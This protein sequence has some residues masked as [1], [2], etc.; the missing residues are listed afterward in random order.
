DLG[1]LDF[2]S[3]DARA[4]Y[5]AEEL[6]LN[7]RTAPDLYLD[8]IPL[9]GTPDDPVP[10]ALPA[11]EHAV[12]MRRFDSACLL[13]RMAAERRLTAAQIDALAASVAQ[14]HAAAARAGPND[15]YGT[16]E[17]I[18]RPVRQNFEQIAPRLSDTA[19][20]AELAQC[21]A[22]AGHMQEQLA[23]TFAARRAA[24]QVRE[25]HGDLH[26]GNIVLLDGRPTPFDCLEFS[27]E[28]RW[29]D[30]ISDAAFLVMDLDMRAG[31]ALAARFLDR[32]LAA[33]G[34]Y[35]GVAVLDYYLAYR[36]LVRAKVELLSK[37]APPAA[38]AALAYLRYAAARCRR[39][40]GGLVIT[41]G[42][43]GSG[44]TT[45]TG[46]LLEQL[47]ALRLRSDLERK[48]LY[49]L[50]PLARPDAAGRARLYGRSAGA[51]TYARLAELARPILAAGRVA[52]VDAT[53]LRAADRQLLRRLA[54]DM[55][56]G[57]AILDC[58][59]APDLLRQRVAS[60]AAQ[61]RDASDADRAVLE[62]Q[63]LEHE[64]LTQ[65]ERPCTLDVDAAQPHS[66]ASVA[67]LRQKLLALP[68]FAPAAQSA[69]PPR[70][71]PD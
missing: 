53:C 37:P 62:R 11:L 2:R 31:P 52:I 45:L 3:R 5:C 24:G 7:R 8:V 63:L 22:W 6:R 28:L 17:C 44:K 55:G 16:A 13:D 35:A 33:S 64:P 71:R 9:G 43:S 20:S 58:Q 4:H 54:Q 59:C 41:H 61:G 15:G 25:G 23:A 50:D 10:G 66:A 21:A 32:Y 48:R 18:A 57:Y 39:A 60:R 69:P 26:L 30:V 67:E 38:P 1:F 47:G 46:M 49:G 40:R 56:A 19:D 14:F 70:A 27:P 68:G 42:F 36:A 12:K 65:D 29:G 34:D 51:A